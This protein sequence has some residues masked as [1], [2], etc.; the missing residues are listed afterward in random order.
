[1]TKSVEQ[2]KQ[3][4]ENLDLSMII[5]KMVSHQGWSRKDAEEACRF[6]RNFLFLSAKYPEKMLTPSKEID[7]FWHNHIL[8]TEKYPIDCQNVFGSYFHHYP[9]TG[10]DGKTDIKNLGNDFAE[11]QLLHK[12]EFGDYIYE[13]RGNL[14]QLFSFVKQLYGVGVRPPRA[15]LDN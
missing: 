1:M 6:Y 10:L 15:I 13:I 7:E 5:N 14:K 4:I 9:Y 12:E 11:I 8:D 3:T 2:L